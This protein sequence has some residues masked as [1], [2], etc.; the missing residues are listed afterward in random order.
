MNPAGSSYFYL[1]S[2]EKTCLADVRPEVGAQ[3]WIGCFEVIA[4][5]KLLE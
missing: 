4:P 3:V 1:G 5:L 2:D